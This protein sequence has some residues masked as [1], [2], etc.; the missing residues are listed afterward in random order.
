MSAIC[1]NGC[2]AHRRRRLVNG[3]PVTASNMPTVHPPPAPRQHAIQ[4]PVP[5][6]LPRQFPEL[7]IAPLDP[8]PS[9]PADPR[10]PPRAKPKRLT[11][12]A[13]RRADDPGNVTAALGAVIPDYAY[14][15]Y[16]PAEPPA[17]R[18][19]AP[20]EPRTEPRRAAALCVSP[21]QGQITHRG[22]GCPVSRTPSDAESGA[23]GG[24]GAAVVYGARII[25]SGEQV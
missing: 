10:S 3:Y 1:R 15:R 19:P 16:L 14:I 12:L 24:S 18:R 9:V 4:H 5:A 22:A 6:G 23:R 21:R 20:P 8:A 17:M 2:G 7:H 11:P 25:H 13:C